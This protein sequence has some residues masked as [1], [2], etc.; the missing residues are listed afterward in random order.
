MIKTRKSEA[1]RQ[2]SPVIPASWILAYM[3]FKGI[4]R[5]T[6]QVAE[7]EW[8]KEEQDV[9]PP[10]KATFFDAFHALYEDLCVKVSLTSP[11]WLAKEA[12]L[13]EAVD[14]LLHIA[15][16]I[17]D[18]FESNQ[19]KILN[20]GNRTD[21]RYGDEAFAIYDNCKRVV[22]IL[23]YEDPPEDEEMRKELM[24]SFFSD[25]FLRPLYKKVCNLFQESDPSVTGKN[26]GKLVSYRNF[27]AV[28][29]LLETVYVNEWEEED[30]SAV[31]L[32]P[33]A[34]YGM[35]M[36]ALT[37][38]LSGK[39]NPE[40]ENNPIILYRKTENG[41]V[42]V[43]PDEFGSVEGDFME[44]VREYWT[45]SFLKRLDW[46]DGYTVIDD[47]WKTEYCNPDQQKMVLS[48]KETSSDESATLSRFVHRKV[49]EGICSTENIESV[50][51][52]DLCAPSA[53]DYLMLNREYAQDDLDVE[54]RKK[55]VKDL[56]HL[57]CRETGYLYKNIVQLSGVF[58]SKF[59]GECIRWDAQRHFEQEKEAYE[60][61]RRMLSEEG[62]GGV[63][64]TAVYKRLMDGCVYSDI[65]LLEQRS[66]CSETMRQYIMKCILQDEN[67]KQALLQKLNELS[68][69]MTTPSSDLRKVQQM[70]VLKYLRDNNIIDENNVVRDWHY[71]E[72]LRELVK[73]KYVKPNEGWREGIKRVKGSNHLK[74]RLDDNGNL[75]S[76]LLNNYQDFKNQCFALFNKVIDWSP[77]D[78]VFK[79]HEKGEIISCSASKLKSDFVDKPSCEPGKEVEI[80]ITIIRENEFRN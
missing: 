31:V 62:N 69:P 4:A 23:D 8:K 5:E 35:V 32:K 37:V 6:I 28:V 49:F 47:L 14:D 50:E 3:V 40:C 39:R 58:K 16:K 26:V 7:W 38:L 52:S 70:T 29:N 34:G 46:S 53:E 24:F 78:N 17:V 63:E 42:E 61:L 68:D 44:P 65:P 2:I 9:W 21:G 48:R 75:K 57:F 25:R 22:S 64:M 10:R 41:P 27:Q 19:D 13:G 77:F 33:V 59:E 72:L 80:L 74:K 30:F 43:D 79:K 67:Y 12:N 11:S 71:R 60:G 56:Y 54:E 55:R 20:Y 36:Y 45:S 1:P 66:V 15:R 73:N 76:D 51:S 18:I